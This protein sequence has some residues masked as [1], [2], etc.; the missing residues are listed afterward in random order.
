MKMAVVVVTSKISVRDRKDA[1]H[2]DGHQVV[3]EQPRSHA[4][5]EHSGKRHPTRKHEALIGL[6]APEPSVQRQSLAH[7]VKQIQQSL[8]VVVWCMCA[9]M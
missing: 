7:K 1:D 3:L 5:N 6:R 4:Q 8:T 2:K 9:C